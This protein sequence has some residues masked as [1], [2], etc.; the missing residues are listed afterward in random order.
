MADG[1][2][3][4]KVSPAELIRLCA[5]DSDLFAH[6]FFP[7]AARQ[8][9]APFSKEIW[10]ALENPKYRLLNIKV[11]RGG[12]K[13]TRLRIFTAKRIAY[14][15][16]RTIL[17]VGASESHA[18][19]SVQWLRAQIEP[20]L[21]ADGNLHATPFAATFG[22]RPGKKWQ[23]HEIEIFHGIDEH[24]IW[25]LGVGITGNIRGINFDDYRPDLIIVDDALTDENAQT[26]EQCLKVNDLIMGALANSLS[27]EEKNSK[28]AMLNTPLNPFDVCAKASE[29]SEW[30]TES[31]GCWTKETEGLPTEEQRSS[32]EEMFPTKV[33]QERKLSS[34]VDNRYSIFAREMECM[35]VAAESLSFRPNWVRFYED[36]D[37]PPGMQCV[38]VIDPVPPASEK[39][40]AKSQKRKDFEAISV[41][42]RS[43][44]EYYLLDYKLSRGHDPN[45]TVATMFE[46]GLKYRIMRVVVETVAYQKVLKWLLEK[47]MGRRGIYFA[48]KDTKN[49]RRPKFIRI[50]TSLSGPS[51]QGHLWCRKEHT[52]FIIQF[53]SYGPGYRGHD[54][55]L[56]TV[57]IGVSELTNPYLELGASDYEEVFP[58]DKF[59][60][61]H[62]ACP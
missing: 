54:D 21:G 47:E 50:V 25:V 60:I 19:R 62:S 26:Q 40:S 31:F 6:T 35:L 51:S 9:S 44:G 20:R 14:G 4:A 28:L 38:L 5:I 59:P 39:A 43:K 45:W 18:V 55:L 61:A 16:S 42:G 37:L 49:D 57:A 17:Y 36:A 46:L 1:V 52:E 32:W 30:H 2:E 3:A 10:K 7:K 48:T 24:P 56:E 34:L 41:I 53:Q 13:T 11:F 12:A 58:M 15:V 29:S 8:K 33:L 23:E 27:Q 22:L